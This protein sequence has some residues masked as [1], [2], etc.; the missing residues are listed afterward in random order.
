MKLALKTSMEINV[1]LR[2]SRHIHTINCGFIFIII[3]TSL[4][5]KSLMFECIDKFF[6]WQII[7]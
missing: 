2:D 7:D 4:S 5:Q 3:I 6:F 1:I